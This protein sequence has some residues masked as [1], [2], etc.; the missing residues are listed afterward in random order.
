[1]FLNYKYIV[2]LFYGLPYGPPNVDPTVAKG[3]DENIGGKP[4]E[5]AFDH[6]ALSSD[7]II[8]LLQAT[9]ETC[10]PQYKRVAEVL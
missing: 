4:V 6:V 7:A 8:L 1:M 9:M 3:R 10:Y 5:H 2:I